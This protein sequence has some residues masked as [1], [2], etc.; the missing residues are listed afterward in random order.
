MK[1]K[2]TAV[3]G[4]PNLEIR[5]ESYLND[6]EINS[7]IPYYSICMSPILK[8]QQYVVESVDDQN[9]FLTLMD[10]K[11][12]TRSDIKLYEDNKRDGEI[13]KVIK[14]ALNNKCEVIVTVLSVM[15]T[16]RVTNY[17]I[18]KNNNL[19]IKAKLSK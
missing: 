19:K 1:K 17:K 3:C 16:D 14:S 12:N 15:G 7:V 4:Q 8:K 10:I 18:L 13:N 9:N 5:G 2:E 6:K 11:G